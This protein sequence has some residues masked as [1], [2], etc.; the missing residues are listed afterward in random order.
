MSQSWSIVIFGYNEKD[1]IHGVIQ[2]SQDVLTQMTSDW[3]IIIV[4]DGSTDGTAESLTAALE[5][6]NIRLI[7]HPKNLGI[8]QALRRGFFGA[9]KENVCPIPA[10][11]EYDVMELLQMPSFTDQQF[12]SFYRVVKTSYSSYRDVLSIVNN[13]FNRYLLGMNLKDVNWIKVF[14]KSH[15]SQLQLQLK[16]SL[17]QSEACAKLMKCGVKPIEFPSKYTEREF[18][19]SKGGSFKIVIQALLDISRLFWVTFTYNSKKWK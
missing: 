12:V 16:S 10:D 13:S 2:A 11:G 15:I 3:E 18:G 17:V 8:G 7:K 9:T 1:S 19:E 14:K 5:N 4:D 6:P